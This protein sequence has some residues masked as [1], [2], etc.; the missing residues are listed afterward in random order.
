MIR[1]EFECVD[2][3]DNLYTRFANCTVY[4][5]RLDNVPVASPFTCETID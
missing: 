1:Y 4:S 3:M 2:T 5:H